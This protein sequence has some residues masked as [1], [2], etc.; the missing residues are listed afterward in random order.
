MEGGKKGKFDNLSICFNFCGEDLHTKPRNLKLSIS[1]LL[2][3]RDL[4]KIVQR[5]PPSE[6]HTRHY[7]ISVIKKDLDI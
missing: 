4:V 1:R 6:M 2:R 5:F 7:H 3:F